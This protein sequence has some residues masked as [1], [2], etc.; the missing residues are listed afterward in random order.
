MRSVSIGVWLARGEQASWRLRVRSPGARSL[1]LQFQD[2]ELPAG[3]A[4]WVY[5]PQARLT[6]GPYDLARLTR[7]GV[8]T[9][10]VDGEEIVVGVTLMQEHGSSSGRGSG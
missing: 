4:L 6:H 9:P 10:P 7:S 1:G 3:A 8:W 5:D 2:F